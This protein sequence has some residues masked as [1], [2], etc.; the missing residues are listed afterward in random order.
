MRMGSGLSI[1]QPQAYEFTDK[2]DIEALKPPF[3]GGRRG[4]CPYCRLP[5]PFQVVA[6]KT[7]LSI[8]LTV[9][10]LILGWQW[11]GHADRC[12]KRSYRADS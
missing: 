12:S 4:R 6:G 8:R 2:T 3:P 10:N 11:H 9:P 5:E 7:T 1:S